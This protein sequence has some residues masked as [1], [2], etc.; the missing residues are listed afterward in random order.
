MRSS[1]AEQGLAGFQWLV[2]KAS[3]EWVQLFASDLI[4][5]MRRSNQLGVLAKMVSEEPN[6]QSFLQDYRQLLGL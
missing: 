4:G 2:E 3:A 6:L 5:Q 1:S